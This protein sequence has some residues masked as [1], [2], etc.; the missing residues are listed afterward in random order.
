M[1]IWS[2]A[3]FWLVMVTFVMFLV[4]MMTSSYNEDRTK[5]L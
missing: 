3:T 4:A 2:S 1:E 5:G